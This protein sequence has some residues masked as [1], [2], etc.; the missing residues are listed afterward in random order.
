[1][2]AVA[3]PAPPLIHPVE[4]VPLLLARQGRHPRVAVLCRVRLGAVESA[5]S[6]PAAVSVPVVSVPVAPRL[7][8][9]SLAEL[10]QAEA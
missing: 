8:R 2:D 6:V 10:L 5:G 4:R 1:M 3:A 9:Q 7:A